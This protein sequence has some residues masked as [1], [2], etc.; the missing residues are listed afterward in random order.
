MTI[1]KK[2]IVVCI[3]LMIGLVIIGAGRKPAK[4]EG[5]VLARVNDE[6]LTL[7]EFKQQFEKIKPPR[8]RRGFRPEM[9]EEI[10]EHWIETELL[11]QEA[12]RRG[13]DRMPDLLEKLED[14]KK[15]MATQTLIQEEMN[16]VEVSDEEA[17][18]YFKQ[19]QSRFQTPEM[20]KVKHILVKAEEEAKEVQ[21]RLNEG[22]EFEKLAREA[23]IDARTKK[24]G[25]DLGSIDRRRCR[26]RFGLSFA[27]AA[28][29]LKKGEISQPIKSRR[30]Y[31]LIKLEEKI[32]VKEQT[33]DEV[34]EQVKR[35][36]LREKKMKARQSFIESLRK[37][38]YIKKHLELLSSPKQP[39]AIERE[40][41]FP[42]LPEPG[43]K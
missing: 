30:G 38:A 24:R 8:H 25:G 39:P 34:R 23:S 35:M 21:K 18:E 37:K 16:K 26:R 36:A 15:Q 33:F 17:A 27:E 22:E 29:S 9:R 20:A 1:W 6:V 4:K 5:K 13:T 31:H 14:I 7:K 32:E 3:A 41:K 19:H 2:S 10:V 43:K 40:L 12:R 42:P 11:F 28:F